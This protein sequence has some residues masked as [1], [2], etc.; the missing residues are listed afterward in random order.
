MEC[1]DYGDKRVAMYDKQVH[2]DVGW[3]KSQKDNQR[4]KVLVKVE[5]L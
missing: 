2:L 3:R 5:D 1:E 4:Q